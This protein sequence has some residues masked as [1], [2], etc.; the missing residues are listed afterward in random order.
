MQINGID[1]MQRK[2]GFMKD[3]LGNICLKELETSFDERASILYAIR[4]TLEIRK[5]SKKRQEN[6][7]IC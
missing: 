1:L 5:M 6:Q 3:A 7:G 2:A 4:E